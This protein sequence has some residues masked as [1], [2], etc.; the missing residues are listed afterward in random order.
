MKHII[1]F[2]NIVFLLFQSHLS[3]SLSGGRILNTE[4]SFNQLIQN[5]INSRFRY[6]KEMVGKIDN[7]NDHVRQRLQNFYVFADRY[8]DLKKEIKEN[9]KKI[10]ILRQTQNKINKAEKEML[11]KT[12]KK[13]I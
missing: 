4:E 11:Q 12:L 3:M 2:L 5:D 10:Q 9:T 7:I 1:L 13:S 8:I 6:V